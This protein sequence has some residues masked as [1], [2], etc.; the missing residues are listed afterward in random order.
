MTHVG[1]NETDE[2]IQGAIEGWWSTCDPLPLRKGQLVWA[3]VSHVDLTPYLLEPIGRA[4]AREHGSADVQV[5][6]GRISSRAK[7]TKLP[8]A[9]LPQYDGEVWTVHRAKKRPCLVVACGW[10]DVPKQARGASKWQTAPTLL[11]A[12]YYGADVSSTRV[13][14]PELLLGRIQ[15]CEYPQYMLDE[16]PLRTRTTRSV[17]RFDHIQPVGNH[18][19]SIEATGHC[20]GDDAL[21]LLDE[22]LD[23]VVSGE[24]EEKSTL[25]LFRNELMALGE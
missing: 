12:P 5:T 15:R 19:D 20:L 6:R 11:V 9:A 1:K 17:L 3:F 14:F 22:W 2:T 16:L 13:G 25:E 18:H 23:W 24:I 8:V 4:D 21:I 10:S 7:N